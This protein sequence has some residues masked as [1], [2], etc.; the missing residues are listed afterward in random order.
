[1]ILQNKENWLQTS[2]CNETEIQNSF[3]KHHLAPRFHSPEPVPY[4]VRED[5]GTSE[6]KTSK[7][8][9]KT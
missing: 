8:N 2:S 1:M 5:Y 4:L 6:D 9:F 7:I 3:I